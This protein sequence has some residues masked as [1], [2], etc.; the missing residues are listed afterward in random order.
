MPFSKNLKNLLLGAVFTVGVVLNINNAHADDAGGP[1]A[2]VSDIDQTN[3]LVQMNQYH[4]D[5]IEI[6]NNIKDEITAI[7]EAI[8]TGSS[9]PQ[10]FSSSVPGAQVGGPNGY[11]DYSQKSSTLS[12]SSNDVDKLAE[13]ILSAMSGVNRLS[14]TREETTKRVNNKKKYISE[15]IIHGLAVAINIREGISETNTVIEELAKLSSDAS[16]TVRDDIS[17]NNRILIEVLK[18]VAQMGVATAINAE[19]RAADM[20]NRDDSL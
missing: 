15:V 4:V 19:L 20:M 12:S 10:Y 6:L 5:Q 1:P 16:A 8:G 14:E 9:A 11:A 17:L 7:K 13:E 3:K 18:Y 2:L